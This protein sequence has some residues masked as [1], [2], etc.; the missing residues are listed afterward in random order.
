MA[1]TK[2]T[3]RFEEKKKKRGRKK[4]VQR[5]VQP[6]KEVT[7]ATY[8]KL[9]EMQRPVNL[10]GSDSDCEILEISPS[11][12]CPTT[13]TSIPSFATPVSSSLPRRPRPKVTPRRVVDSVTTPVPSSSSGTVTARQPEKKLVSFEKRSNVTARPTFAFGVVQ[14]ALEKARK[15]LK[16]F[17][18]Q[19]SQAITSTAASK[20]QSKTLGKRPPSTPR[21]A[22]STVTSSSVPPSNLQEAFENNPELLTAVQ[23]VAPARRTENVET[24]SAKDCEL[25][26]KLAVLPVEVIDLNAVS[27]E[28]RNIF[29]DYALKV[30]LLRR[31]ENLKREFQ[32]FVEKA[33]QVTVIFSSESL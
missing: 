18:G 31:P 2:Q 13:D 27:P 32:K 14:K 11:P 8:E 7:R 15:R 1:R 24:L 28:N 30:P 21:K 4:A 12:P 29:L 25:L 16:P 26:R 5:T 10:E 6:V 33:Q 17:Q 20:V 19:L 22:S 23:S 9:C 3:K